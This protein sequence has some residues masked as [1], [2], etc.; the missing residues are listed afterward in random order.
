MV[1]SGGGTVVGG[2]GE[3]NAEC[4]GEVGKGEWLGKRGGKLKECGCK[5][6]DNG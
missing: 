1:G 2:G 3:G 6:G 5:Q 4:L